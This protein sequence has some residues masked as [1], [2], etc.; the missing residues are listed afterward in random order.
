MDVAIGFDTSCYTTSVAAVDAGGRVV[1]S[2]RTLLPVPSGQRGLRQSEA[3]FAHIRQVPPLAR[4][5][6][7]QT[8]GAA[9]CAVAAS[10]A[11]RDARDS[12]MPVFLVGAGHAQTLASLMDVPCYLVS[13]QQGHIAAGELC[14]PPMPQRFAALHLSGGTTEL[15]LCEGEKLTKLGGSL[16]L[17]AG[18]LIDRVGVKMGLPFP[19]GPE[20]EKLAAAAGPAKALLPASLE[21][22]DLDCHLSGA[23]TQ[24][25]RWIQ[26][27]THPNAKIAAE[28]FDLLAR[29]VAR[30]IAA[31][32]AQ[33]DVS[34]ALAVGGVASSALWREL[35]RARLAKL[36]GGAELRFGRPEYSGDNAAGVAWLGMKRF[37][38]SGG[39]SR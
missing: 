25:E 28:V 6:R 2:E 9:V 3:V 35:T 22:G 38:A 13:H 5:V 11:P 33:A 10:A 30:M 27:G 15:L 20:L 16:D 12:Y 19:A 26:R 24:C 36:N 21:R 34:Q 7:E 18:Q 32:C 17:H 8:S 4:R 37:L 31:A 14:N 1:A 29:T 39:Q 23:E